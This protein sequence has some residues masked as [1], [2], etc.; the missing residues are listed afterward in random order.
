MEGQPHHI[1][2][3]ER[4]EHAVRTECLRGEMNQGIDTISFSARGIHVEIDHEKFKTTDSQISDR[5]DPATTDRRR[6]ATLV[7]NSDCV[8]K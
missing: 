6:T 8:F 3:W 7:S 1:W 4:V 2:P 5:A